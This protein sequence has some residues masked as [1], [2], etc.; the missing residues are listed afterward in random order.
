MTRIVF[1]FSLFAAASLLLAGCGGGADEEFKPL[2]N[3]PAKVEVEEHHHE[4]GPHGGH[5]IDLGDHEYRAELTM[6]E[7]SRQVTVYLL[8]HDTDDP[9]AIEAESITLNLRAGDQPT[10][11]TLS[12]T[13]QEGEAEGKSSRFQAPGDQIPEQIK[14]IEELEGELSVKIGEKSYTGEIEHDHDHDH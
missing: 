6:D 10:Q 7:Q 12:A 2:E 8:E 5:I 3:Q 9:V 14:D 11:V 4:E 13:P 1:A